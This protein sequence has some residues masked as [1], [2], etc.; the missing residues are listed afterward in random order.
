MPGKYREGDRVIYAM[1][2]ASEHPGPRARDVSPAPHGDEYSY[3]V[4]KFWTVSEVRPE[5][6][7]VIRTRRGKQR[8]LREEDPR[9]RHAN[10]WERVVHRSRFPDL[11]D[12]D[13]NADPAPSR[14]EDG[15][16]NNS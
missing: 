9:L 5:G 15:R 3:L 12:R 13:R 6:E 11:A 14:Q 7:V 1:Q 8:T 16:S 2:K 10:L 4:D